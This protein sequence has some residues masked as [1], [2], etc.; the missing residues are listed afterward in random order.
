VMFAGETR[1]DMEE[2]VARDIEYFQNSDR[3]D[4]VSIAEDR[5]NDP[6]EGETSSGDGYYTVVWLEDKG[7]ADDEFDEPADLTVYIECRPIVDG[8][9][10]LLIEHYAFDKAYNDE[11]SARNDLLDGI[12]MSGA[13]S[14]VDNEEPDGA[15]TPTPDADEEETPEADQE[16]TPESDNG[17]A[18]GEIVV[19]IEPGSDDVEGEAVLT[20]SGSSR[21]RVD[22][23]TD[24]APE[25]ALVVLQEGS[26]DDLAGESAFDVGE[27]DENGE[28]T[29]RVRITPDDLDGNYALTIVDADTE[30]YEEPL[31][32]GDIG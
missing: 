24:G 8:E 5:N 28:A 7:P 31:A 17:G 10:M 6:L 22:V 13:G 32:C 29:G 9:S 19:T 26:C 30:D 21:T 1:D 3:Y 14:A 18:D 12:D 20:P 11:I 2:C 25:G 27:I 23:T 4:F 16:E 15:D